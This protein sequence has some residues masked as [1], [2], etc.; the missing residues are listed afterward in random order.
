MTTTVQDFIKDKLVIE[1]VTLDDSIETAVKRMTEHEFS[2][3]PV[4]NSE[5]KPIGIITSDSILQS[6]YNFYTNLAGIRIKHALLKKFQT[7]E[8]NIDLLDLFDE[9]SG[10]FALIVDDEGQLVQIITDYD[11][12]EYFRQRAQDTILVEN[13]ENMLKEFILLAFNSEANGESKLEQSIQSMTNSSL[14]LQ[15]KFIKALKN[16]LGKLSTN[17]KISFDQEQANKIFERHLDDK[18]PP[19]TFEELSLGHYISLFLYKD[20]WA[21]IQTVLELEKSSLEN[22]LDNVRQTRNDLSHFREISRDQSFQLRHCYDLLSA[23]QEAINAVFETA[24]IGAEQTIQPTNDAEL[25]IVNIGSDKTQQP[26]E[27]EPE[28]GD[29]RYAPLAI[30]LQEQPLEKNLVKPSF[31]KIEEIIGG[32]LP[33]SAYKNRSWWANDSAGHV[34]SKQ[35]LDVGWRVASADVNKQVARFSRIKERQRAYIDFYSKL[36]GRLNKEPQFNHLATPRPD[37]VNWYWL[38]VVTVNGRNLGSF[39]YSF[40]RGGI[41]RIEFYID[42]GDKEINK[43]LFDKLHDKKEEIETAFGHELL[44]QRMDNRRASRISRIYKA[45]ITD[46]PETLSSLI[47]EAVPAMVKFSTVIQSHVKVIE[48]QI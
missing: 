9:M 26:V 33:A 42:S 14:A 40:G 13:I 10:N 38:K 34:Q 15:E 30:W 24:D 7:F 2:Q 12:A 20:Y 41:F 5:N 48:S 25:K 29:S 4:V 27:E 37:G 43:S 32:K 39:N 22:L 19:A 1:T 36:I 18:R 23:H 47:Q 3:L 31:A 28:P 21:Q 6:V 11:T 16:Y 44:W 8:Q 46:A 17:Q 35:W 45:R